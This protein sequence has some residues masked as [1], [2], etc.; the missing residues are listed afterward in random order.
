MVRLLIII[1]G[2]I[3]FFTLGLYI[4]KYQNLQE[5]PTTNPKSTGNQVIFPTQKDTLQKGSPYTLKWTSNE[6]SPIAIFLVNKA[7]EKQ[8]VSISLFDRVYNIPNTGSFIY[9]VPENIPDGEYKLEIGNL[10][11]EYFQITK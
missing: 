11:S 4:F 2:L 6:P 8:G 9:T 7:A 3:V 10:N 5:T 1:L